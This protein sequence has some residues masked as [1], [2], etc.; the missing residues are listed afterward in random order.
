MYVS[1]LGFN[2]LHELNKSTESLW[3]DVPY[4]FLF[5]RRYFTKKRREVKYMI[6][7]YPDNML[8]D[9]IKGFNPII[10]NGDLNKIDL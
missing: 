2:N 9:E 7:G 10:L 6:N 3:S 8:Y 5:F 1:Y 4:F